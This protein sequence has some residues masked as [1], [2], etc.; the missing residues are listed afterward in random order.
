MGC[1]K[2]PKDTLDCQAIVD[3]IMKVRSFLKDVKFL[4]S[5]VLKRN[6]YPFVWLV[7]LNLLQYDCQ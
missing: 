2:W 1:I 5:R 3:R 6:I 7:A 4:Y